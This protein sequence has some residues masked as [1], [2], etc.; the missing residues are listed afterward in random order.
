MNGYKTYNV[1]ILLGNKVVQE[2]PN[3]FARNQMEAERDAWQA[4]V[5]QQYRDGK[6]TAKAYS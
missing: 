2:I 4:N 6:H 1:A 5:A 3:V